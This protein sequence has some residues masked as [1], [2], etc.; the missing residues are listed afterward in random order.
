MTQTSIEEV[1]LVVDSVLVGLTSGIGIDKLLPVT[2][3]KDLDLDFERQRGKRIIAGIS[4]I[5][6]DIQVAIE[7]HFAPKVCSGIECHDMCSNHAFNEII[8]IC[9]AFVCS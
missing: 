2:W 5:T 9:C 4:I 3:R 7:T 8:G 6:V 1:V